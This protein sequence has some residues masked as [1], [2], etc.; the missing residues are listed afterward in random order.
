MAIR[1]KDFSKFQHFK[2]RSPPWVK[3]YRDILDDPD[4]HELDGESAKTLV[5]LWLLASED[6]TKQGLLPDD[7]KLCFRLR[8]DNKALDHAV[9]KLSHWLERV[10][11]NAISDRY[12]LDAPERAGEETEESRGETEHSSPLASESADDGF[13]SF[14]EQYPKKVAKPQAMKAWKK[15]KPAGQVIADLM[16]GLEQQKA[17]G[18]W[19]KD[20]G[21]FI[22]HP[23]TWLNGRRWEDEAPAAGQTA[24]PSRNPIFA[25]AV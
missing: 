25:G 22:P 2:D 1:I 12:Q 21:Q 3:L 9:S 8:I 16:A 13:A 19:Q 6:E 5:M 4:W 20:G 17:S 10:D 23:A 14:W 7:R 18:D 11:I 24:A 15:I